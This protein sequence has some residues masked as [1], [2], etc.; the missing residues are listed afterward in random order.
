MIRYLYAILFILLSF[1]AHAY[2]TTHLRVNYD[3]STTHN[4]RG[5]AAVFDVGSPPAGSLLVSLGLSANR[6]KSG[7]ALASGGRNSITP[8]YFLG[9]FSLNNKISPFVELGFDLGDAMIDSF[10]D[11]ISNN[12]D[13]NDNTIDTYFSLGLDFRINKQMDVSLYHKKYNIQYLELNN[14]TTQSV[15]LGLTG[16]SVS[17]SI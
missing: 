3:T 5:I 12:S 9:K 1:N 7:L 4:A 15:G 14:P 17:F 8:V 16:I 2:G 6:I 10:I 11:A 13:D